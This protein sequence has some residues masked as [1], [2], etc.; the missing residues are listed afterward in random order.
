MASFREKT[1]HLWGWMELK[2]CEIGDL[3]DCD[4]VLGVDDIVSLAE[5]VNLPKGDDVSS[6]HWNNV[7]KGIA[8]MRPD[9]SEVFDGEHTDDVSDD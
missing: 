3:E 2:D 6:D 8:S 9:L 4:D 7:C 1:A 5:K